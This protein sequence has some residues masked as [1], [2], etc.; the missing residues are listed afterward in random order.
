MTTDFGTDL[1]TLADGD[2]DPAFGLSSGVRLVAADVA[3]RLQTEALF[4]ADEGAYGFDLREQA[5]SRSTR[6]TIAAQVEEEALRD[7]RV[8]DA[9]AAA[10]GNRV[11]L[12]VSTAEGPFR[13]VVD[14]SAAP[15][16]LAEE[17]L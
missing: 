14:T 16:A 8:L 7:D 4:Y 17:P 5:A 2:L 10:D 12:L 13:L 1:A 3:R 15:A 11:S 6:A 9:R